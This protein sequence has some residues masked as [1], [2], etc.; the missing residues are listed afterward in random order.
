MASNPAEDMANESP[1]SDA[2][3]AVDGDRHKADPPEN[4]MERPFCW[5]SP[6]ERMER[7][8]RDNM[9]NK[10]RSRRHTAIP[11]WNCYLPY[12]EDAKK[13]FLQKICLSGQF[14]KEDDEQHFFSKDNVLKTYMEDCILRGLFRG[15]EEQSRGGLNNAQARGYSVERLR[16]LAEVLRTEDIIDETFFNNYTSNLDEPDK[17]WTCDDEPMV[18]DKAE[19]DPK[20][21]EDLKAFMNADDPGAAETL[22]HA[23]NHWQH[24]VF[25]IFV[26]HFQQ[27]QPKDV[28][29]ISTHCRASIAGS[30]PHFSAILTGV[31]A[32]RKSHVVRSLIVKLH[33]CGV[34]NS[35]VRG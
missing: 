32:T 26:A 4:G 34:L 5:P 2:D 25:E 17:H 27:Q 13:N 9:G 33:A 19:M 35:R 22:V 1:S 30:R 7:V 24:M 18:A 14:T 29:V 31:G 6:P 21:A 10:W 20:F 3:D 8:N 28:P 15:Y 23:P 11:R 12:S 16:F